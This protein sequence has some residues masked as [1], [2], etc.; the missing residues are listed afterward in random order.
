MATPTG[1]GKLFY[2]WPIVLLGFG[3][4]AFAGG[5]WS[6][7]GVFFKPL[8]EEF[9]GS[10]AGLSLVITVGMVFWAAG[11]FMA[12]IL[13][14]RLGPRKLIV[15]GVGLMGLGCLLTSFATSTVTLF[16]TYSLF[17]AIGTGLSTMN[18]NSV[19]VSRWFVRKRGTALG[20]ST[21]G[22]NAGQLLLIPFTALLIGAYGWRW[23]FI[24]WAG[25]FWVLLGPVLLRYLKDSP[26]EMDLAPDGDPPEEA[27]PA[28]PL[29]T[30]V[31]WIPRG[32]VR[33][34]MRTRSFW[35]LFASYVGCGFTDFVVYVHFPI[36]ATGIGV[37]EQ[38]AANAFGLIGGLS[39]IGVIGM[40]A[41]A[42]R[43]GFKIPLVLIYAVRCV[44]I[45]LLAM[46]GSAAMLFV[47]V[48]IYGLLHQATTPLTPGMTAHLY[49]RASLG[50][51]YSYLLLGHSLG[52]LTGPF[53]A[54]ATF[55]VTGSYL[56]VFI[57]TAV[58]LAG[59]SA[60]CAG[61]RSKPDR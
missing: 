36:F 13:V 7:F 48:V 32:H 4:M 16:A 34:A 18:V 27:A 29:E 54:G 30:R 8:L 33:D 6:G 5:I 60:C 40:G 35:L 37:S 25:M 10:R 42:D 59:A 15:F 1:R 61:V 57:L 58:I 11:Q 24:V 26:E 12:G 50:T 19:L 45:L 28:E 38:T 20:A 53:I 21:A 52:A 23:A 56:P 43:V 2:G 49:G 9:G 22:Y 55:D 3:A 31:D 46:T 44:G 41:W 14:N 39:I 51:L 17:V 47:A